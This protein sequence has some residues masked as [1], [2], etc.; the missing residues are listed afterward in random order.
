MT[1]RISQPATYLFAHTAAIQD[2]PSCIV[3]VEYQGQT[4]NIRIIERKPVIPW[5][6]YCRYSNAEFCRQLALQL[7]C[8]R[9]L[10]WPAGA[11]CQAEAGFQVRPFLPIFTSVFHNYFLLWQS[12]WLCYYISVYHYYVTITYLYACHYIIITCYYCNNRPLL[13]LLTVVMG[14]LLQ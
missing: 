5:Y 8:S 9:A 6:L 14:P 4:R 13:P 12:L 11:A 7:Q 3:Q 1:R 10:D 2:F